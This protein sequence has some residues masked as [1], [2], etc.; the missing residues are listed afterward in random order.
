MKSK[1]MI[2]NSNKLK[3]NTK[4]APYLLFRIAGLGL[5][6]YAEFISE[7]SLKYLEE[8]K[9]LENSIA[10][11]AVCL[12]EQ[13]YRAVSACP[14]KNIKKDLLKVKKYFEKKKIP[15]WDKL[16]SVLALPYSVQNVNKELIFKYMSEFDQLVRLKE[17]E[18]EYL[19]ADYH[20]ATEF[21]TKLIKTDVMQN[22]LLLSSR[23]LYEKLNSYLKKEIKPQTSSHRKFESSLIR[24]ITR[25]LFKTSPFSTFT[26]ISFASVSEEEQFINVKNTQ[27]KLKSFCYINPNIIKR[28]IRLLEAKLQD[29]LYIA[30]NPSIQ[31]DEENYYIPSVDFVSLSTLL[32]RFTQSFVKIKRQPT[33]DY[34]FQHLSDAITTQKELIEILMNS[35]NIGEQQTR[36]IITKLSNI[37]F[38]QI[39]FLLDD[40]EQDI[41]PSFVKVVEKLNLRSDP[42]LAET[43]RI[44]EDIKVATNLY[45]E[46]KPRERVSILE[47]ISSLVVQ[48]FDICGE[49]IDKPPFPILEDA[50]YQNLNIKLNLNNLSTIRENLGF[51]TKTIDL[52]DVL[53]SYKQTMKEFFIRKYGQDGVCKNIIEFFKEWSNFASR[54][55][56]RDPAQIT[57]YMLSWNPFNLDKVKKWQFAHNKLKE[58]IFTHSNSP[59]HEVDIKEVLASLSELIPNNQG[60]KSLD[61]MGQLFIQ[62]G[63]E[64]F[65]VNKTYDG[66]GHMYSRFLY[67][68][69]TETKGVIENIKIENDNNYQDGIISDIIGYYGF[70]ADIR[71]D[72][73][74]SYILY[75]GSTRFENTEGQ[76]TIMDIE[77]RHDSRKD[78]LKIWSNK[79]ECYISPRFLGFYNPFLLPNFGMFLSLMES[80]NRI[81]QHPLEL[82]DAEMKEKFV[83]E[84][85]LVIPRFSVGS[86]VISRKTWMIS[87]EQ[88][89]LPKSS[90]TDIEYMDYLD[91][92]RSKLGIPPYFFVRVARYTENV[93]DV[94]HNGNYKDAERKPQY[95]DL[96]IHLLIREF[97]RYLSRGHDA[98][99]IEEMLPNHKSVYPVFEEKRVNEIV[100][101]IHQFS[102]EKEAY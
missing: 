27:K 80:T 76:N 66:W 33:L 34:L 60:N 92:W 100:I 31:L 17:K 81:I 1:V 99:E 47:Q 67:P 13:F 41:I 45:E 12:T 83:A 51:I 2:T 79:Q 44:L 19:T 9:K 53:F 10:K 50:Y 37:N 72:L 101:E 82:F 3:D 39:G 70:P 96:R 89:P 98:L 95:I 62:D 5:S 102:Q 7:N 94:F 85:I 32:D 21:I 71:P 65:V 30:L 20:R 40:Y 84:G 73:T 18:E 52:N 22:G 6:D 46:A 93:N 42:L 11:Q 69:N 61:F 25:T 57:K 90:M 15:Q 8:K 14:D 78:R 28:I 38:F 75:P 54:D 35:L 4:I 29:K 97:E 68:N 74:K 88:F 48:L 26:P 55:L 77:L 43:I 56:P 91:Q 49:S 16:K 63:K 64:R 23:P 36:Q 24:Y 59:I 87:R 58:F 86:V